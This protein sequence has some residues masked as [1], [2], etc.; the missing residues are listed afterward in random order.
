MT[1]EEKAMYDHAKVLPG[2]VLADAKAA[3]AIQKKTLREWLS[4]VVATAADAVIRNRQ[5]GRRN[6]KGA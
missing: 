5:S 1:K 3:A 6:V 4:E 2:D